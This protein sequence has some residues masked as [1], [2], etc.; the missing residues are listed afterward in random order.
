VTRE[1][2]TMLS[3]KKRGAWIITT[4]AVMALAVAG[5]DGGASG[6]G[7]EVLLVAGQPEEGYEDLEP[8]ASIGFGLDEEDISAPGPTIRVTAGEPVTVT[9]ENRHSRSDG[10]PYG[11][12]HNFAVLADAQELFP[13]PLWGS[14]TED[15]E[16][17]DATTVTFTPESPGTYY[18]VCTF[19]SHRLNGMV[20]EFIVE[21]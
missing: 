16:T 19:G 3:E 10:R 15:I 7:A 4:A 1:E 5:C 20:G 6:E 13:E 14:D 8:Q 9:F 12:P 2:E 18:Y 17:G 21:G 11:E